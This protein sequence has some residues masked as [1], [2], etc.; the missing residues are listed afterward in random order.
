MYQI[1]V[2]DVDKNVYKQLIHN[3]CISYNH[4]VL[5]TSNKNFS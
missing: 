4:V 3:F 2:I 5:V 1:L